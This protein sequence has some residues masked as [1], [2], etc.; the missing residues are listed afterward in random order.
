MKVTAR[1]QGRESQEVT[2]ECWLLVV[3]LGNQLRP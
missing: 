2:G 1:L 3:L